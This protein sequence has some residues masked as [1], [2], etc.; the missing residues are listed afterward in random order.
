MRFRVAYRTLQ[1]S[2]TAT[3]VFF[4]YGGG[5]MLNKWPGIG[6][7]IAILTVQLFAGGDSFPKAGSFALS[8]DEGLAARYFLKD[9]IGVYVGVAYSVI[10][11]DT[12]TYQPINS[13]A[14]KIG[15][16]YGIFNWEKMRVWAF[17]EWR[18]ELVQKNSDGTVNIDQ[19][20]NVA[21]QRYN[22]F[23]T[24]FRA[25]VRPELFINNHLS[26]D[27]KFGIEFI[28]HSADFKV[29]KD[30]SGLESMK[31]DF[32]EFGVY[33]GRYPGFSPSVLMNIGFNVY[34]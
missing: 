26:F 23:N 16:E 33:E 32:S 13:L 5:R 28:N 17:G 7:G 12:V 9:K 34:F 11:P 4:I 24:I 21:H 25:G 18:E 10:G 20:G 8:Y 15:G 22:T 31:N 14:V 2:S 1:T 6:I 30:K 3:T 19:N 27:Y 29:N